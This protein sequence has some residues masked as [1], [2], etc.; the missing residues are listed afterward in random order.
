MVK[1]C[2]QVMVDIPMVKIALNARNRTSKK[3]NIKLQQL[4]TNIVII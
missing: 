1:C 3:I 2:E 4:C